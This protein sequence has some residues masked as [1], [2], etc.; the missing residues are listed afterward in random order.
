MLEKNIICSQTK[1]DNIVHEQTIICRQLFAGHVMSSWP[2]QRKKNLQRMM[3][4]FFMSYLCLKQAYHRQFSHLSFDSQASLLRKTFV[5]FALSI[6][7]I[8]VFWHNYPKMKVL[9]HSQVLSSHVCVQD[10]FLFSTPS[11]TKSC[12]A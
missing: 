3:I 7:S 6:C 2:V 4:C 12:L 9:G 10:M 8:T 1:L 11:V 5:N